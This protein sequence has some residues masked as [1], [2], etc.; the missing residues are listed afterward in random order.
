MKIEDLVVRH[1]D[2][3]RLRARKYCPNQFEADDLASETIYKCL[4]QG[5]KYNKDRDFKPWVL[6]IMGNT[7]KT[8]YNRKKCVM[9]SAYDELMP[10]PCRVFSDQSARINNVITI[11]KECY[12]KSCCIECVVLYAKGYSYDEISLKVNIPVGTVKSRISAG[13]KIIRKELGI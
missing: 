7:F 11:I 5:E 1:V 12:R 9:F 13:R 3:I 6:T 8:L 4:S 2:W 10:Y